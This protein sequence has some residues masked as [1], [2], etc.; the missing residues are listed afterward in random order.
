MLQIASDCF[1]STLVSIRTSQTSILALQTPGRVP[2]ADNKM[3]LPQA[4]SDEDED[5]DT[6]LQLSDKCLG[7]P[8]NMAIVPNRLHSTT[9]LPT[10]EL[11]RV[12]PPMLTLLTRC[13]INCAKSYAIVISPVPVLSTLG[14]HMYRDVC[15]L[16]ETSAHYCWFSIPFAFEGQLVDPRL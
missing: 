6:P 8:C 14:S 12:F 11:R 15:A 1:R 4:R 2:V 7:L 9:R 13:P 16:F 5:E 10:G 3:S